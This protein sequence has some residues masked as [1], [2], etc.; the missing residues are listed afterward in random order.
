MI[1]DFDVIKED[2][3]NSL[4]EVISNQT[5]NYCDFGMFDDGYFGVNEVQ[6]FKFYEGILFRDVKKNLKLSDDE[7]K[8]Y[9]AY[10]RVARII[11]KD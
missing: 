4:T 11:A 5:G 7:M 8:A 2:I 6:R 3:R 9:D 10:Q 1:V